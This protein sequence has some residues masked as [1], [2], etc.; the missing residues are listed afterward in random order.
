M[1]MLNADYA[2]CL[3][4]GC[5]MVCYCYKMAAV[6]GCHG[7]GYYTPSYRHSNP[8]VA[9]TEVGG[10]AGEMIQEG[11]R[12]R[13][14]GVQEGVMAVEI[15]LMKGVHLLLRGCGHIRRDE[16]LPD[17]IDRH[18]RGVQHVVGIETIVAKFVDENFVGREIIYRS[19]LIICKLRYN[20]E[21]RRLRELG[22]VETVFDVANRR[23]GENKMLVG[24][25]GKNRL[26]RRYDFLHR[27]TATRESVGR[28]LMAVC[29]HDPI[30]LI[31][32][33]CAK[34]DNHHRSLS[35]GTLQAVDTP[36]DI[37]PSLQA[38][39]RRKSAMV[40]H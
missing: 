28:N 39:G 19:R 12:G 30:L 24:M 29:H 36:P 6:L 33:R 1:N 38:I 11:L 40:V 25:G 5:I 7:E 31:D 8:R 18:G 23:D 3:H 27:E 32:P 15:E 35:E 16:T 9:G 26:P 4:S 22:L 34:S 20:Q 37:S 10:L 17:I 13:G 14:I 2:Y 21:E